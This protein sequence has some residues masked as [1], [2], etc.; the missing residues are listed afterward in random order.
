MPEIPTA[1]A[2]LA[3]IDLVADLA[4]GRWPDA[5]RHL[6]ALAA[7]VHR[8]LVEDRSIGDVLI[9]LVDFGRLE[10]DRA[11]ALV[12]A[13]VEAAG[14][15]IEFGDGVVDA[16][17]LAGYVLARRHPDGTMWVDGEVWPDHRPAEQ[18]LH[19]RHPGYAVYELREVHAEPPTGHTA[20]GIDTPDH[21]PD[22][23]RD[24]YDEIRDARDR[25]GVA[26]NPDDPE[27]SVRE[28][29][30]LAALN[31]GDAVRKYGYA[32]DQARAHLVLAAALTVI[33]IEVCD[34]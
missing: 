8:Q 17:V 2:K 1:A 11:G 23:A 9:N 16:Q 29:T 19:S 26:G 13:A 27:R 20:P 3:A 33:A 15:R 22:A 5:D 30:K 31:L 34:A 6:V 10:I 21:A 4:A 7:D 24:I 28:L 25:T 14:G 12:R 32:G 18:A